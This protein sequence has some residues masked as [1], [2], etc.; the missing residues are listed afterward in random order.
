MQVNDDVGTCIDD[1]G[2]QS[3]T[4]RPARGMPWRGRG[5]DVRL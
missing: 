2:D 3:A 4:L 1:E 5:P